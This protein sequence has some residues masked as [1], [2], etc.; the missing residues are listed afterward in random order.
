MKFHLFL[1]LAL[2][3]LS[4]PLLAAEGAIDT[5]TGWKPYYGIPG[6]DTGSYYKIGPCKFF[7]YDDYIIVERELA[8][9][10]IGSD[11][12]IKVRK[13]VRIQVNCEKIIK[14]CDMKILNEWAEFFL[15]KKDMHLIISSGTGERRS[16]II[17]DL[18]T[19]KKLFK[20]DFSDPI[21]FN[22]RGELSFWTEIRE[23]SPG[24][25]PSFIKYLKLGGTPIIE[26]RAILNLHDLTLIKSTETRCSVRKK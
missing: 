21:Y 24:E 14:S 2:I 13:R 4:T 10:G 3:I 17:Y 9:S 6:A 18:L 11:I 23:A 25:C 15:A 22:Y 16:L 8:G 7:E 20:S 26:A 19:G 12:F 5:S 1:S